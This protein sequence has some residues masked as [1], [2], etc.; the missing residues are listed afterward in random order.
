MEFMVLIPARSGSKGLS[1]KNILPIDSDNLI[2]KA[3]KFA[4]EIFSKNNIFIT[5]DYDFEIFSSILDRTRYQK[6]S[7]QLAGDSASIIDVCIDSYK[8]FSSTLKKDF[9]DLILLQPTSPIRK[10]IELKT[11]LEFYKKNNLNS[12]ASVSPS[13][14]HPY[15][16]I[17]GKG[18]KWAPLVNWEGHKNRQELKNNYHFI[19]GCFYFVNLKYLL[20][21]KKIV[22]KN[23]FMFSMEKKYIIDIDDNED[24]EILKK[25]NS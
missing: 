16:L 6:R 12:L 8:Y 24:F 23:T 20:L 15:E 9:T 11:A 14:Q 17:N 13:I 19:N 5:T 4:S 1:N 7:N 10:P 22:D 21:N 3:Y 2:E 18:Q 25:L